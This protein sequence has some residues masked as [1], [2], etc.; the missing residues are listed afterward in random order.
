M[1][2]VSG[3]RT[4]SGATDGLPGSFAAPALRT[5][6]NRRALRF[7][8]KAPAGFSAV[9]CTT[10]TPAVRAAF[11]VATARS[12]SPV[13]A[14]AAAK[15]GKAEEVPTTPSCISWSTSA[16]VA[17]R[18]SVA[19]S[20]AMASVLPT[21]A[22]VARWLATG[23]EGTQRGVDQQDAL[24]RVRERVVALS[25]CLH[26]RVASRRLLQVGPLRPGRH[27]PEEVALRVVA[28]RHFPRARQLPSELLIERHHF[29][30]HGL[31]IF[32]ARARRHSDVIVGVGLSSDTI[33]AQLCDG[34]GP[35]RRHQ[36][37]VLTTGA[38]LGCFGPPLG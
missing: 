26:P 17:G 31:E 16:V 34:A 18:T 35:S 33:S 15:A 12:I 24:E 2:L 36:Q 4:V 8:P 13:S 10:R 20:G 1:S 22:V 21:G 30:A 9:Q 11:A 7:T 14:A 32:S 5:P 37:H 25:P 19:S 27:G 38:E 6:A 3:P 28:H 29:V 23:A